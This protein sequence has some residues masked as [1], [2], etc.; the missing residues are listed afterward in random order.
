MEYLREYLGL[1]IALRYKVGKCDET[2]R[3]EKSGVR[4]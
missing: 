2:R 4:E 1:G 3:E